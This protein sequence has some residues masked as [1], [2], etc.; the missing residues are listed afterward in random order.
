[1]AKRG[2]KTG[3]QKRNAVGMKDLSLKARRT[4]AVSGGALNG[5]MPTTQFP[6]ETIRPV[7]VAPVR[8]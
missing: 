4:R 6:T 8:S 3:K 5:F 2:A 1:M 7:V